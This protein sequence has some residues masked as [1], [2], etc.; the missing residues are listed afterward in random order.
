[1][2][3]A[4]KLARDEAAGAQGAAARPRRDEQDTALTGLDK[5]RRFAMTPP[6]RDA[7]PE[8]PCERERDAPGRRD[9][10]AALDLVHN[11][12]EAIRVTEERAEAMESRAQTL[13]ERAT[14]ELQAAALRIQAA[15]ARAKAAEA[16]AQ[17]AEARA[18]DAEAWLA[19]LHDVI[20][21][22]LPTRRPGHAE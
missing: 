11:A 3:H 17:E 1:M 6:P 13:A 16:R 9:W 18:K 12:A 21:E 14:E 20:I 15:E 4:R 2:D 19:R 22:E 5:V 8:P 10:S 7:A